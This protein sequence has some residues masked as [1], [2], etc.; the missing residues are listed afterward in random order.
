MDLIVADPVSGK[1]ATVAPSAAPSA[2]PYLDPDPHDLDGDVAYVKPAPAPSAKPP[3][4][5]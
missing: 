1:P 2:T 3:V 5:K 4:G